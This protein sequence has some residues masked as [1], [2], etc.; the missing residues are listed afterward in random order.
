VIFPVPYIEA[1]EIYRKVTKVL[2][3]TFFVLCSFFIMIVFRSLINI[4]LSTTLLQLVSE[5]GEKFSKYVLKNK[6][7]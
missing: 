3:F 7:F 1:S 2:L 4:P 6:R 5:V